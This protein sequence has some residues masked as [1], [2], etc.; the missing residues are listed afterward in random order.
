MFRRLRLSIYDT[1]INDDMMSDS[2]K[3]IR[4]LALDFYEVTLDSASSS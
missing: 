2:T 4:L 3:L 1:H